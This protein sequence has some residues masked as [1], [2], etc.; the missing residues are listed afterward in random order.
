MNAIDQLCPNC[1]LCCNGALFADVEL[2]AGD[3]PKQLAKLGLP[4]AR[5]GPR[6]LAFPQACACFD[7]KLCRIYP[8]RPKRCRLFACGLLKRVKAGDMEPEAALHEIA[9]ARRQLEKIETFLEAMGQTDKTLALTH[10][11]ASAMSAPLDLADEANAE[12][13]GDLMLEMSS[14]MERFQREFLRG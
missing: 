7:G 4:L 5:K 3:D 6:K 1:G 9:A 10:R 2:R 13:Y 8:D 14:L 12:H 11:Y